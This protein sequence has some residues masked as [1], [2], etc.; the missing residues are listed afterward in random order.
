MKKI[1]DNFLAPVIS[2][3]FF[4]MVITPP[5][6]FNLIP[7]NIHRALFRKLFSEEITMVIYNLILSLIVFWLVKKIA[8][9]V[10]KSSYDTEN[11][12]PSNQ[13]G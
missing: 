13:S 1:V 9:L 2:I 12:N 3:L 7:A 6:I 4:Y 11:R 10:F 5:N 8:Y